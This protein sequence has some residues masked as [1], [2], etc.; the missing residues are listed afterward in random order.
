[1]SIL[2]LDILQ[3]G[4]YEHHAHNRLKQDAH[5]TPEVEG[6]PAQWG[7]EHAKTIYYRPF[8]C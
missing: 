1:M 8:S 7:P 4:Y 3:W 6:G 5:F 2:F